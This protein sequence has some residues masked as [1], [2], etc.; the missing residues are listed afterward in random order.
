M[1]VTPGNELAHHKN[2]N[3]LCLFIFRSRKYDKNVLRA[4]PNTTIVSAHHLCTTFVSV[5]PLSSKIFYQIFLPADN[6]FQGYRGVV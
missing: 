1:I 3:I 2:L 4:P 6:S 5:D